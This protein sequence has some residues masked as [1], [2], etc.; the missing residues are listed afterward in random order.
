MSQHLRLLLSN[1]AWV[2]ERTSMN[3][4]FF[5]KKA[6]YQSPEYLWIGCSD[7]RVPAE[8][9]TGCEPGELF[10]HRNIANLIVHT[11][12][13]LLS[14][15]QY[16]VEVLQVKHVIVCGHYGCGGIQNAMTNRHLGLINKWLR[17]IKDVYRFHE[18]ELTAIHD[19]QT[20]FRRLVELNIV[21]QVYNLAETSIIQTAWKHHNRPTLHGWVYDLETGLL[22]E[23]AMMEPGAN[24]DEIYKYDIKLD[25]NKPSEEI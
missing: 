7:S 4:D 1:K 5:S 24:I 25:P 3:P 12:F 18:R 2:K 21:E 19:E 17:H 22:N 9:V 13:N 6:T 10:V 14:V 23:L 16:A 20:K 8:E 11:D 15:L